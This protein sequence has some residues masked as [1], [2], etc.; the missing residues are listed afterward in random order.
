MLLDPATWDLV[1]DANGD[2]AGVHAPYALAQDAASEMKTFQGE[3]WYDQTTGVPYWMDILG[4]LPPLSLVKYYLTTAAELTPDV[5]TARCFI[6]STANRQ[7]QG[8][9]QILDDSG[10]VSAAAFF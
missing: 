9:V 8:Q 6:S 7:I 4:H 1:A 3:V 5:V 10:N 2:M